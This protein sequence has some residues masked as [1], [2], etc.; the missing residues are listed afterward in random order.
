MEFGTLFNL[1]LIKMTSKQ[2][3][4]WVIIILIVLALGYW[5]VYSSCKEGSFLKL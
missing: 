4:T 2:V 1:V 5:R 3:T